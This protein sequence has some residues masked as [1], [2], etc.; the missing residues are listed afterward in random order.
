[1]TLAWAILKKELKIYFVSPLAYAFLGASLF[2]A[3][4]FFSTELARTGEA[5]LRGML[6]NLA[7]TL[8]FLLPLLTMR[9]FAEERRQGTFAG[10]GVAV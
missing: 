7:V 4:L 8:V 9:H 10:I 6:S 1:M 2:L 5:S 3:G